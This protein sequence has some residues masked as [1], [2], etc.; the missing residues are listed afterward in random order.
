M[1]VTMYFETGQESLECCLGV[2]WLGLSQDINNFEKAAYVVIAASC[3][4][5]SVWGPSQ[6]ADLLCVYGNS[7]DEGHRTIP[8]MNRALVVARPF[9][10]VVMNVS[11]LVT[12]QKIFGIHGSR[13]TF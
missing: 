9:D 13:Q 2:D 5:T 12:N 7:C 1:G 8:T 11:Q 10:R 4:G 6:T 3:E